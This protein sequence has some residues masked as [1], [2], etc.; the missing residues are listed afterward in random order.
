MD[1]LENRTDGNEK[2]LVMLEQRFL[3]RLMEDEKVLKEL[4]LKLRQGIKFT[5]FKDLY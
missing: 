1:K 2:H 4:E 3:R 5:E